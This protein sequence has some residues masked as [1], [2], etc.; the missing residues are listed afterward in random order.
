MTV[1]DHIGRSPRAG[2]K[3]RNLRIKKSSQSPISHIVKLATRPPLGDYSICASGI[4][5]AGTQHNLVRLR[6][7]I[8]KVASVDASRIPPE[9]SERLELLAGIASALRG[10]ADNGRLEDAHVYF[11]LLRHLASPPVLLRD[12]G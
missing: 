1:R 4:L 2:R 9:D 3:K 12:R 5:E 8:E 6:E 11:P 7:E 10:I